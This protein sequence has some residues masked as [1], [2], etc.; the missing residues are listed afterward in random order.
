MRLIAF[1]QHG[2]HSNGG[3][4]KICFL[5]MSFFSTMTSLPWL[6][7]SLPLLFLFLVPCFASAI[8]FCFE[9]PDQQAQEMF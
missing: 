4:W 1:N 7:S 5:Y 2:G 9:I 8:L 3:V 6:T